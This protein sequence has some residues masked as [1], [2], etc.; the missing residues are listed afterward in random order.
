MLMS[1]RRSAKTC[2]LARGALVRQARPIFQWLREKN[3]SFREAS[4]AKHDQSV[5]V[6]CAPPSITRAAAAANAHLTRPRWHRNQDWKKHNARTKAIRDIIRDEDAGGAAPTTLHKTEDAFYFPE[7]QATRLDGGDA[8]LSVAG[9]LG[10]QLTLLGCSGSRFGQRMVDGWLDGGAGDGAGDGA[11]ASAVQVLRLSLV[12]TSALAWMRT[13]LL[14][15]IRMATPEEQHASFLCLFGE[16][17]AARK[18]MR[19]TNGFLGYVCLVDAAGVVR[20][21]V[22][23]SEVP[24]DDDVR[25]LRGLVGRLR[26]QQEQR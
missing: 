4:E 6:L 14:A 8:S 7:L 17:A 1:P 15:S 5:Q 12:E 13:P 24:G 2:L 16:A 22:H 20:W 10:G 23:S 18:Q 21:H 19:M 25:M 26:E 9:L 11:A 3:A